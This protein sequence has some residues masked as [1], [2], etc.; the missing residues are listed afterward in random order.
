MRLISSVTVRLIKNVLFNIKTLKDVEDGQTNAL[1]YTLFYFTLF[2]LTSFYL[3]LFYFTS[4][5]LTLFYFTLFYLTSFY[6]TWLDFTWLDLTLFYWT[7]LLLF[8]SQYGQT[9]IIFQRRN[10]TAINFIFMGPSSEFSKSCYHPV[11]ISIKSVE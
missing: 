2:Y 10:P 1:F 5:Y 7:S 6:W 11:L 9:E 3:T 8:I 4:F